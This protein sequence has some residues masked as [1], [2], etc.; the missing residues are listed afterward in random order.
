MPTILALF[1]D[2]ERRRFAMARP[3]LWFNDTIGPGRD[4]GLAK[5]DAIPPQWG[6]TR[7]FIAVPSVA[8]R[9]FSARIV[10]DPLPSD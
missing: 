1:E 7:I 6:S 4:V 8:V 2:R 10:P 3:G 5:S 9:A